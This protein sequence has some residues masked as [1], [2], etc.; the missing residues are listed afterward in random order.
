MLLMSKYVSTYENLLNQTKFIK[1]KM[2]IKNISF[3]IQKYVAKH[4]VTSNKLLATCFYV[5]RL[6]LFALNIKYSNNYL[7]II[8]STCF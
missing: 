6:Q 5:F 8:K 3:L 1:F 2:N 7:K 4:V